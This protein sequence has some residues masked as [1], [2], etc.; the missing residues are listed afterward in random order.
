[1]TPL[2]VDDLRR[3]IAQGRVLVIVGAGVSVAATAGTAGQRFASWTGLLSS[4]IDRCEAVGQPPVPERWAERRREDLASGDLQS[5]LTVAEEVAS[6]LGAPSGG[7]YGR[8]L[9]ETVGT[10]AVLDSSVLA[11][12]HELGVEIATTNYD[13]LIEQVTGLPPVTWRDGARVERVVR[14]D[15]P[16]VLHLHGHWLEPESVVL[17]IRSYETVL[18]SAHAQAML[19][20]LRT[21]RTLLFIGCGAGLEDP[22][23]GALLRW[24]REVFAGSEYRHFRLCLE[25]EVQALTLVHP[26]EERLFPVAY[27][28][29]FGD[30]APFLRGLRTPAPGERKPSVIA[31]PGAAAASA[32]YA[33]AAAARL[34]AL[35]NCFGRE[36]PLAELIAAV[37]A[38]HPQPVPLLGPPGVGKT[39]LTVAC[40]HAPRVAG[41]F[42][43]RRFFA[44]CEG[45]TS[46]DALVVVVAA[47]LGLEAGPGL[48]ERLF[49]ALEGGLA[50]LVLDNAETP[51]E[52]EPLAVEELLAQLAAVP[53]VALVVTVRGEQRPAGPRW[54]EAIR[55]GPLPLASARSAFLA[56]AGEQ[57]RTDPFL[58]KLVEAVEGLPI[59]IDLLARVAEALPELGELWQRWETE[60]SALLRRMGGL[61]RETNLEVSVLLSLKSPRMSSAGLR[62][63]SLLALLP[64]GLAPED[65]NAVLPGHGREGADALRRTGLAPAGAPRLRLLAPIREVLRSLQRPDPDDRQRLTAHFLTLARLGEQVG[66]EG[67]RDAAQRLTPEAGN[68]EAII[69]LGLEEQNP[70]PALKAVVAFAELQRFTGLGGSGLLDRALPLYQRVGDELGEANCRFRLGVALARSDQDA[71]H[72]CFEKALSLYRRVGSELGEANCIEGLGEIALRRSDHEAARAHFEEALAL[73]CRLGSVLGQANCVYGLGDIALKRSDHDAARAHFEEALPLY[74]RVDAVLGEANCVQRLGDIALARFDYAGACKRYEEALSL[75]QRVGSVRGEAN[76]VLRLGEVALAC[77]DHDTARARF[78]EAL[79]LY[80]RVGDVL[81][82]ANCIKGLGDIVLRRSDHACAQARYE[83]ALPLFRRV[84]SMR[85]EANCILGL[86]KVAFTRSDHDTARARIKEALTLYRRIGDALGEANCVR[87]LGDIALRHSNYDDA[88]ARFEEATQ[89]YRRVGDV[90]GGAN[91][92]RSLGEIAFIHSN[93]DDARARYEEALTV[94]RRVGDVL[95]EANC[96]KGLGDIDLAKSDHDT[97]R[98]RYEQALPLY[99]RIGDVLGQANCTKNLGDIALARSD[100]DGASMFYEKALVLYRHIGS[101]PGEANCTRSLGVVAHSFGDA[102]QAWE[103]VLKAL[104]LYERINDPYSIGFTHRQLARWAESDSERESQ[105]AAARAAWTCIGRAD[106]V[107]KLGQEFSGA[108]ASGAPPAAE[109]PPP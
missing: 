90:R 75:L 38:D 97:A 92:V 98:A 81:G 29:G 8:W 5:L 63:G 103:L 100:L 31:S 10:L 83:E 46:R 25:N 39:T 16:G 95:G 37:L 50:L 58:D 12:I 22:N 27:G 56:V 73:Y 19:R 66:R 49:R 15:E 21:T 85:G 101:V 71:A 94:Y 41:R 59:A 32:V 91:C 42:G 55:L 93:H 6:R 86:G 45:A 61:T 40:L 109:P 74:R 53:G 28:G 82:E 96:V 4:G 62:L 102:P 3:E 52:G 43:A 23:F 79:L 36:E 65:L 9:R 14:G 70:V 51:W 87:G 69:G 11:A 20:A 78:E 80:R 48:V 89:L 57:H 24:S 17:G 105:V 2:L 44:R 60:R 47:A 77:S 34:P 99:V 84:G 108:G 1:V 104:M 107:A 106:L 18:G 13:S 67:G 7:E 68:L 33:G 35:R 72:A 30:L 64:D 76:C 26:P 88:R 54:C